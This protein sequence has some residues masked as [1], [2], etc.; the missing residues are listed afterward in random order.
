[1]TNPQ[2]NNAFSLKKHFSSNENIIGLFCFAE[3]D[4]YDFVGINQNYETE[5]DRYGVIIDVKHKQ[6]G[7]QSQILIDAISREANW[8]QM[9]DCTYGIGK[10]CN[11]RIIACSY[12]QSD[13]AREYENDKVMSEGFSQINN[14]FKVDTYIVHMGMD[15][16]SNVIFYDFAVKPD[17][18][19]RTDLKQRPTKEE[20]EQAEFWFHYYFTSFTVNYDLDEGYDFLEHPGD[21]INRYWKLNVNDLEIIYPV[22]NEEG[23]FIHVKPCGSTGNL[24]LTWLIENRLDQLQSEFK[25]I[26]VIIEKDSPQ[27]YYMAI[28]I[29]DTPFSD[30]VNYSVEE[31]IDCVQKIR[32]LDKS[33]FWQTELK[34]N[35]YLPAVNP[36]LEDACEKQNIGI[37]G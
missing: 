3:I 4:E 18:I 8:K 36:L 13:K 19:K 28:Q 23:L 31:K 15:S 11:K 7:I 1:M 22:W 10:D 12:G 26:K 29:W 35:F 33:E 37:V 25:P 5:D 27:S 14:D 9:M 20:M 21:W 17:G 32:A 34:N 24:A 6:T 2:N 30:F 16:Q